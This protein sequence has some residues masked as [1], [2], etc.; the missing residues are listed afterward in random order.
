MNRGIG[1]CAAAESEAGVDRDSEQ[2]RGAGAGL[3][4]EAGRE[5]KRMVRHGQAAEYDAAPFSMEHS[6]LV[7]RG[8][9]AWR[10]GSG[11]KD[12]GFFRKARHRVCALDR[13]SVPRRKSS[14]GWDCWKSASNRISKMWISGFAAPRRALRACMNRRRSRGIAAAHRWDA[15]I[16]ETVRRMA[17]NRNFLLARHY[18]APLLWRW[19]RPILARASALGRCRRAAWRGALRGCAASLQGLTGCR[20]VRRSGAPFSEPLLERALRA[21]EDERSAGCRHP[22]GCDTYWRWYFRLARR[23]GITT[24]APGGTDGIGIVIVT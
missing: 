18:P 14:N 19:A 9:T 11:R 23:W 20:R 8:G 17:R 21:H 1:E 5:P 22:D 13:R 7:C 15:G 4:R 2:R 24:H 10:A 12:A 6:T 16:R 3:L